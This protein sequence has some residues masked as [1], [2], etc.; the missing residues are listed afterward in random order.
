MSMS[1]ENIHPYLEYLIPPIIG[2]L[3]GYLTNK[4][5]IR[6]L[7]RPLKTWRIFGIRVPM[8]PGVIPSKRHTLALNMGEMVGEHLLTSEEIGRGLQRENFQDHLLGLIKERVGAVL[9]RDL[10]SV[11]SLIPEKFRSYFDVAARTITYQIKESFHKFIHSEGFTAKVEKYLNSEFTWFL[12][13]DLNSVISGHE[14]QVSYE[15]IETSL[16]RMLANPAM[17]QWVEDF[18][19]RKVHD[20]VNSGKSLGD[21]LPVSTQELIIKAIEEQTPQLLDKLAESIKEPSVREHIVRTLCAWIQNFISSM[22]PMAAMVK[23]FLNMELIEKKIN[24]YLIDKKEDIVLWMQNEV[25]H[26]RITETIREHCLDFFQTPLLQL[27]KNDR[28][29]KLSGICDKMSIQILALLREKETTVVLSSMIRDNIETHIQGGVLP[30]QE[31]LNDLFGRKGVDKFRIW[32]REEGIALLRSK[33]TVMT[34]DSMIE[35]M[36]QGLLARPVGR[37]SN[38]LPAG[39]RD[40]MYI[41]LRKMASAMLAMEVPGLVHSLNIRAIVAEKVDSLDLLR[42]ERLLLSIMEEQFKYINLFGAILGFL[43]G[44]CNLFFL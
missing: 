2:A 23:G 29:A 35:T 20:T 10:G 6:M 8:T 31:I 11:P 5:A 4:I 40:G 22:G 15:F 19:Y 3:I 41:S 13:K 25:V 1:F 33:E 14:R 24:E 30:L 42:L 27:I 38:L 21:L 32:I 18:V 39:V 37:L 26:K 28:E 12:E 7:F 36:I 34:I 17:D 44:C 43:I 9:H 16:S